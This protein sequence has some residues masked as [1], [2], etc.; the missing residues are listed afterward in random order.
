MRRATCISWAIFAVLVCFAH[1]ARAQ[2]SAGTLDITARITPT[3]AR[4]EPVRQF[5]FYVL[6]RSYT[7]VAHDV[8]AQNVLP[9]RD[10][11]IDTLKVSTELKVWLKAHDILDLTM[12]E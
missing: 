12:P 7:D 2:N 11:F 1:T 5:T 4:P 3:A 8:G 9:S 10:S 6:T